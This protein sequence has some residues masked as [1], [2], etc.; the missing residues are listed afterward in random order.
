MKVVLSAFN[1]PE[2]LSA[3]Y[4][5]C[6]GLPGVEITDKSLLDFNIDAVVSPANSFGFMDGGLD[7][8]F[9]ARFPG[10]EERVRRSIAD[11]HDGELL[12][13]MALC[14]G[15]DDVKI[16]YL[17]SAPTMRVPMILTNSVNPYLAARAALRAA[18]S[19]SLSVAFPGMGTGVGRIPPNV[20]ARQVKAAIQEVVMGVDRTPLSWFG[21]QKT[22]QLLYADATRDLQ[23]P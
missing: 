5:H 18:K 19:R 6:D 7:K 20:C 9:A 22:H 14:V 21:A 17:I 10:I 11:Y 16:P 12:V 15:T 4:R 3:W 13:G 8:A 2:L 23:I 1:N